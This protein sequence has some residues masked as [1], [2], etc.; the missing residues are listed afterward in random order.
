MPRPTSIRNIK[1]A[2]LEQTKFHTRRFPSLADWKR[3]HNAGAAAFGLPLDPMDTF[4]VDDESVFFAPQT[5]PGHYSFS[6]M[7]CQREFPLSF[8]LDA[9]G[10]KTKENLTKLE[11]AALEKRVNHVYEFA[12]RHTVSESRWPPAEVFLARHRAHA[13][14]GWFEIA[15]RAN[16]ISK[17]CSH[18][19]VPCQSLC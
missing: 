15:K 19:S 8:L 14:D 10:G 13:G 3:A 6:D 7:L 11:L 2:T 16:A 12:R 5:N 17:S 9:F 18:R 1:M 4:S